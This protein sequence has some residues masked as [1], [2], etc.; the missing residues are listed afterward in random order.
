MV[1]ESIWDQAGN[2]QDRHSGSAV[3]AYEYLRCLGPYVEVLPL[4][5]VCDILGL[6]NDMRESSYPSNIVKLLENIPPDSK[7][8]SLRDMITRA[9]GSLTKVRRFSDLMESVLIPNVTL[10]NAMAPCRD[11]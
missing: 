1:R 8:A 2:V 6:F 4:L 5:R 10:H 3:N 11:C 7:V 9:T